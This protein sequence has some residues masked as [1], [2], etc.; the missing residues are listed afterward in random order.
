MRTFCACPTANVFWSWRP[1]RL[2][3]VETH[4]FEIAAEGTVVEPAGNGVYFVS[5]RATWYPYRDM[6]F[7]DYDITFRYP[8]DLD[9]VVSGTLV[10]SKAD[11]AWRVDRRVTKVPIR[12]AG[13]NVGYYESL[14]VQ[15]GDLTVEVYANKEN[16]PALDIPSSRIL[17]LPD[18]Q[19][20]GKV[21]LDGQHC[22]PA[23]AAAAQA[24]LRAARAGR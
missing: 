10:D 19:A 12:L 22:R 18:L 7:A 9:L 20:R 8:A 16:E 23:S 14:R 15:R 5:S 21:R 17:I 6:Q 11:G 13:F 1:S 3:P 2:R 4:D 24:A